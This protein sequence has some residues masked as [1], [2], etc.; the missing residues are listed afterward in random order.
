MT[1]YGW[2]KTDC[3][4]LFKLRF[5][6]SFSGFVVSSDI[7]KCMDP[8][9]V[10]TAAELCITYLIITFAKCWFSLCLGNQCRPGYPN[11]PPGTLPPPQCPPQPVGPPGPCGPGPQPGCGHG[12]GHGH[13]HGPGHG[14]GHGK[15]HGHG[16]G[17]KH[18][19][20]HG[21]KHGHCHKK[22]KDCRGVRFIIFS[23]EF[24]C[25]FELTI[26]CN[27]KGSFTGFY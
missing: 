11:P 14:H 24:K 26:E 23:S 13:G 3:V 15:G 9:K 12:Q 8:T 17:H 18:K 2:W 27:L 10:N 21:H 7:S 5:F 16:H 20:K 25:N 22:G 1:V 6:F 4:D 19:H